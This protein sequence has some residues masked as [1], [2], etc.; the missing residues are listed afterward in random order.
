MSKANQTP[1]KRNKM[2]PFEGTI[3]R[4]LGRPVFAVA[5]LSLKSAVRY[6]LIQVLFLLL[7][8]AVIGL[9]S[10]IKHDGTAQGFTQILLTYTLGAITVLLGFA[11][12]WIGCGSLSREV[13][14]CQIQMVATKPIQR[15]Q[16][17]LGK[18]LGILAL[19]AILLTFSGATVY[20][21][22]KFRSAKL[23][24]AVQEQLSREIFTARGTIRE[25]SKESEIQAEAQKLYVERLKDQSIS[26]MDRSFVRTG[27]VEMVK[28]QWQTVP[29]GYGRRWQLNFG[30]TADKVRDKPLTVR[31][32]FFTANLYSSTKTYDSFW[33]VGPPEGSRARMELPSLAAETYH[34]FPLPPGAIGDDGTLTID[35]Y[36]PN[37]TT[38]IFPLE[39]GLEVLYPESNFATNFCR[40]L[41][42][43]FCWL[44]LLAAVGLTTGSFLS[45]PVAAFCALGVLLVS[46]STGTLN[47]IVTE[48][49]IAGVNTNT[50]YVTDPGILN[51]A[52]VSLAKSLLWTINLVRDFSPIESLSSG[53]SI[54]WTQLAKATLQIIV[55]MGGLFASIGISLFTRRELAIAQGA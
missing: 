53:R 12:L 20:T 24:T 4:T 47:Q 40:A 23:P 34:E 3:G 45:F 15:W 16:I 21:L 41:G 1:A 18:W 19:N 9:P 36:N 29:A 31:A 17:W 55:L 42:I 33:E 22:L 27:I 46:S 28:A 26:Q 50:G 51:K 43:I 5:K 11:T 6:R 39:E 13:E 49:G 25:A 7:A 2:R 48:Q 44:A 32:K 54:T 14:E 38:L 35:F 10:V 52:S 8:A 30:R 37:D